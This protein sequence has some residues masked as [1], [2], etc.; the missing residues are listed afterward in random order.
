VPGLWEIFSQKRWQ[1][2]NRFPF[3]L[4]HWVFLSFGHDFNG[5]MT[6]FEFQSILIFNFCFLFDLPL[7]F[8]RVW[9]R[10]QIQKY[11]IAAKKKKKFKELL[12]SFLNCFGRHCDNP[13]FVWNSLNWFDVENRFCIIK[14]TTF[15]PAFGV[16][17]PIFD[18]IKRNII[19]CSHVNQVKA[20]TRLK[21]FWISQW[22]RR[23]K[24]WSA[25]NLKLLQKK[26]ATFL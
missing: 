17:L 12:I 21:L 13:Y 8:C 9:K 2:Q 26:W 25:I 23:P 4:S 6:F 5:K 22:R 1:T 24:K 10:V 15:E 11:Q 20:V 3:K 19:L 16:Y 14:N 18:Q 7:I